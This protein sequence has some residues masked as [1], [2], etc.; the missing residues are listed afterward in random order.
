M[1]EQQTSSLQKSVSGLA[2][3]ASGMAVLF[4]IPNM[5][6]WFRDD[7]AAYL[8]RDIDQSIAVIGSWLFIVLAVL[9][10]FFALSMLLQFLVRLL[11]R[12]SSRRGG[13]Y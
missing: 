2:Y 10:T 6:R 8:G 7:V 12:A 1:R 5:I 11:F 9:F 13:G 3:S 4:F